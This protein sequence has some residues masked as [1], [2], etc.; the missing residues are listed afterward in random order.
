MTLLA[1]QPMVNVVRVAMQ[2][3]AAVLG[4]YQRLHTNGFDEALG[5]PTAE[6]A[7]LVRTQQVIG[8]ESGLT[9]F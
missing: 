4:G 5:L 9:D 6:A 3:L 2:T 7:T 1:Q 8:Y